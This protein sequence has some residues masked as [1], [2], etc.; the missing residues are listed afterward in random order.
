MKYWFL[1]LAVILPSEVAPPLWPP[2]DLEL[3]RG[4]PYPIAVLDPL[5]PGFRLQDVQLN[6]DVRDQWGP[7]TSYR[8]IY[9]H[10]NGQTLGLETAFEVPAPQGG[11]QIKGYAPHPQLGP[12]GIQA[13]EKG[14]CSVWIGS[15]PAYRLC[16]PAHRAGEWYYALGAGVTP[17]AFSEAITR[18]RW[19]RFKT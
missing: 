14:H 17:A 8:L 2:A 3:L 6:S 13:W 10:P 16:S 18:L 15:A 5:P 11:T 4:L 9:S 12:W 1:L 7:N 19:Y